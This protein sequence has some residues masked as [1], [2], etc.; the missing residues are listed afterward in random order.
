MDAD[1]IWLNALELRALYAT[2]AASPLDTTVAALAR[3]ERYD[4]VLNAFV[5]I[6]DEGARAQAQASTARWRRNQPLSPLDGQPVTIKDLVDVAGFPTRCGSVTT[7]TLP[8]QHDAPVV[9]RLREAGCI[10]LGKTTTPEF[11]WKGQTDSALNGITRNP[12]HTAHTPGGSSGGAAAALAAGIGTLA[13]GN[14]GGGSV[15]IPASSCGLFGLKPTFGRVPHDGHK[16]PFATLVASGPLTRSVADAAAML[17]EMAKP[18]AGDC[19]ALPYDGCDYLAGLDDGVDGLRI[20]LSLDFAGA[21][22]DAEIAACVSAAAQTFATLGAHVETVGPLTAALRPRFEL[23][24]LAG[25][26]NTLRALPR[27]QWDRLDPGYRV[28]AEQGLQVSAAELIAGE[29]A[30]IELARAMSLFH[31]RYDLLLTPTQPHTPVLANQPYHVA[32]ND[33]WTDAT[34]YTVAFNYTGQPAAT[35]RCG[36]AADGLPIGLQIIGPKYAEARVL[37]AA[38]AYEKTQDLRWP[39]PALQR[40]LTALDH[41]GSTAARP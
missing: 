34:V 32:G 40:A 17:N 31:T 24:W 37:R 30:R 16:S 41:S 25:F 18:D 35:I 29:A 8:A 6:D 5:V 26:A 4:G 39:P 3:I 38:R 27:T 12:W 13:Q 20:G 19:Y 22:P 23:Y 33:R 11:G 21:Q 1:L 2:R 10:I 28:L 7:P 14:D 36:I 9:A 15:R